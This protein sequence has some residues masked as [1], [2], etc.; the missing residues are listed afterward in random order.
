V[1]LTDDGAQREHGGSTTFGLLR[2]F[3]RSR[4]ADV[5]AV[6][7]ALQESFLIYRGDDNRYLPL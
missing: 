4:A 3:P 2:A 6:L 7:A 1:W 5:D